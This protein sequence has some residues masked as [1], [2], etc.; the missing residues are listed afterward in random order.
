MTRQS[1]LA[2][3]TRARHFEI[4]RISRR[5]GGGGFVK[6]EKHRAI[7]ALTRLLTYGSRRSIRS[8]DLD[9]V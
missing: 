7:D 8:A 4:R 3:S 2:Y 1:L 6:L 9:K 5:E